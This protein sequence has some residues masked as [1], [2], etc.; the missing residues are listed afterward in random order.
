MCLGGAMHSMARWE[1]CGTGGGFCNMP[2]TNTTGKGVVHAHTAGTKPI[3]SNLM[4]FTACCVLRVVYRVPCITI[5]NHKEQ[6]DPKLLAEGES[7]VQEHVSPNSH[8][9]KFTRPDTALLQ[10][11]TN[12]PERGV[13]GGVVPITSQR[14]YPCGQKAHG[15]PTRLC[16]NV[17]SRHSKAQ[18][19]LDLHPGHSSVVSLTSM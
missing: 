8:S 7:N 9:R 6:E 12:A 13:S 16:M 5:E 4:L 18:Q 15:S 14:A 1:P 2:R 17:F 10:H 3:G 11:G 19:V